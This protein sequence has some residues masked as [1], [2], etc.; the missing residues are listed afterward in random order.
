MFYTNKFSNNKTKK[1]RLGD[2]WRNYF[3]YTDFLCKFPKFLLSGHNG[4]LLPPSTGKLFDKWEIY[5]Q[6]SGVREEGHRVLLA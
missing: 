1:F 2:L 3:V 4:V 5:Y 6:F